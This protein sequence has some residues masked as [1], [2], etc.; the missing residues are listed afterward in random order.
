MSYAMDVIEAI[1]SQNLSEIE[2]LLEQSIKEDDEDTLYMLADSLYQLGFLNETKTVLNHL[3]KVNPLDDEIRIYLAEIAIE[4]GQDLE[5][6]DWLNEI[7]DSSPA[8][9]QSLLV[10]ADYYQ[11]QQ[12]PEVS[13]AKLLE[14]KKL[15]PSEPIILFGL[16]EL[17]YSMAQ[18]NQAIHHYEACLRLDIE[19]LAGIQ[20]KA[21]IGTAYSASGDFEQAVPYLEEAVKEKDDIDT[22]FALGMTFY[23]MEEYSRAIECFNQV[24]TIDLTY[25]SVYPYLATA[26]EEELRLDEAA[27]VVKEGVTQDESNV[28]LFIIGA[29]IEMKRQELTQAR[30]Y[31]E[32]AYDLNP[33]SETTLIEYAN[34]LIYMDDYS[35]A[36]DLVSEALKEDQVDPQLYW[37]LATAYNHDE[38]YNQARSYYEQA[39]DYLKD[40]R[41]FLKDYAL[42]LQEEGANDQL[43]TVIKDYL[44]VNP[45]DI[46]FKEM[47]VRLEQ[48]YE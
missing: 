34:F 24:K 31:F 28:S 8:Y 43:L 25:S 7:D 18:Y 23:Q 44:I 5:A 41:Y 26:L 38:D 32:Q 39:Y 20:I 47:L 12:L 35:E 30:E 40:N 1:Q 6:I 3:L 22:L 37:V 16:A 27:E 46:E 11:T 13:E 33:I 14:A 45:N 48:R 19:E 15:L 10:A 2:M 21:R 17:Y 36:I 42:F 29:K 9:V 4:E